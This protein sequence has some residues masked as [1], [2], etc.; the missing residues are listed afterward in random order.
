MRKHENRGVEN[1]I[2][3]RELERRKIS[4]DSKTQTISSMRSTLTHR[5]WLSS[6]GAP[7]RLDLCWEVCRR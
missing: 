5:D 4:Q 2:L 3:L 7:S 6:H 1:R